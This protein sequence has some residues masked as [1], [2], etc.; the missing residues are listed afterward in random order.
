MFDAHT[1]TQKIGLRCALFGLV[2]AVVLSVTAS[3]QSATGDLVP[4]IEYGPGGG[5]C[6]EP[7]RVGACATSA[8]GMGDSC[9]DGSMSCPHTIVTNV[10]IHTCAGTDSG[11]KTECVF[12]DTFGMC[13]M[14]L[15]NC[16]QDGAGGYNCE[17]SPVLHVVYYPGYSVSGVDCS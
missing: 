10:V 4:S 1:H 6:Y 2:T 7:V 11:G 13:H 8:H 12:N 3:D 14:I 17:Q 16:V 5:S 9:P 15:S